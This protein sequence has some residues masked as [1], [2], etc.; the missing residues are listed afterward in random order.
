MGIDD[1]NHTHTVAV[2]EQGVRNRVG[3]VNQIM[4]TNKLKFDKG[5]NACIYKNFKIRQTI[6]RHSTMTEGTHHI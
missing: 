2:L 3:I 4:V 1:V 6:L 5:M